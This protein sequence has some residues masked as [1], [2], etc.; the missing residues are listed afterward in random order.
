MQQ[1][2]SPGQCKNQSVIVCQYES[3]HAG[4]QDRDADSG[5]DCDDLTQAFRGRVVTMSKLLGH[6]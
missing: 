1:A 4:G 6:F 2:E 3:N 5:R